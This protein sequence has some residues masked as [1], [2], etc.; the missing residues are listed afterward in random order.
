MA[1]TVGTDALNSVADLKTYAR[2]R[3][4]SG[5]VTGDGV[6]NAT[7]EAALKQAARSM[8]TFEWKGQRVTRD[9]VLPWPRLG[10]DDPYVGG[11]DGFGFGSGFTAQI[12]SDE[13]PERV[14]QAEM[15]YA[16]QLLEVASVGGDSGAVSVLSGLVGLKKAKVGP[17]EVEAADTIQL[18]GKSAAIQRPNAAVMDLLYPYLAGSPDTVE[19]EI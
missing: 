12:P 15:E 13:T 2:G 16:I 14:K 5:A 9:Q 18:A 7:L 6:E 11:F 19:L 4:Q 3:L 8:N 1:L 10:V 17:I